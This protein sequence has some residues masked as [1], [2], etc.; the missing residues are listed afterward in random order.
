MP[1]LSALALLATLAASGPAQ[2]STVGAARR[3][4]GLCVVRA[5]A[6]AGG[7]ASRTRSAIR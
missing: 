1:R 6:E 4:L 2:T 7:V 3:A 5:A